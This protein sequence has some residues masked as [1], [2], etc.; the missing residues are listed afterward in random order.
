MWRD[1]RPTDTHTDAAST[2][3]F[4][5]TETS[6]S[7]IANSR[8]AL[9]NARACVDRYSRTVLW[10]VYTFYYISHD[11]LALRRQCMRFL[12]LDSSTSMMRVRGLLMRKRCLRFYAHSTYTMRSMSLSNLVHHSRL[13]ERQWGGEWGEKYRASERQKH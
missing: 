1:H 9:T 7:Q 12:W 2:A 8:I 3:S 10:G 5:T 4:D 6:W 13:A 11:A